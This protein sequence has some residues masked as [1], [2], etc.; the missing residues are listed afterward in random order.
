MKHNGLM[1]SVVCGTRRNGKQNPSVSM[2]FKL[3]VAHHADKIYKG[4]VLSI[5]QMVWG[6]SLY[7]GGSSPSYAPLIITQSIVYT[8]LN[9]LID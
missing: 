9:S 1:W 3:V 8:F 6:L 7:D 2:A 4:I 5:G